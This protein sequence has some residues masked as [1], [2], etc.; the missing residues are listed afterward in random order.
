M[1]RS[2]SGFATC[3]LAVAF[4]FGTMAYNKT[5]RVLNGTINGLCFPARLLALTYIPSLTPTVNRLSSM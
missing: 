4:L 2:A 1:S 5:G 3:Y